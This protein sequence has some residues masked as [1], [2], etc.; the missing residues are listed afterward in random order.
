MAAFT[1]DVR[2]RDANMDKCSYRY[3]EILIRQILATSERKLSAAYRYAE[4]F[5]PLAQSVDEQQKF[6]QFGIE[7]VDHFRRFV[8]LLEEFGV[9]TSNVTRQAELK[10]RNSTDGY[11]EM[12]FIHREEA[13]AFGLLNELEGLHQTNE[14]AHSTYIPLKHAAK[15]MLKDD[16]C[17]FQY[18][19]RLMFKTFDEGGSTRERVQK[20]LDRLYPVILDMLSNTERFPEAVRWGL[21]RH[22]NDALRKLYETDIAEHIKSIG[23]DVPECFSTGKR[24]T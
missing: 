7:K 21:R 11:L 3:R 8:R 13:V 19:K 23:Y 24:F 16:G 22:D 14:L 15:I 20:S 10:R 6:L 4:F 9:D 5:Y 17:H 2:R 12:Q 1:D 18:G